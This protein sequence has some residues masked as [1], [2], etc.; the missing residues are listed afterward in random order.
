MQKFDEMYAMLPYEGSDV[1]AHY[2]VY[3]QWL[4]HQRTPPCKPAWRRP[5]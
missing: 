5:R 4:A 3:A 2:K 1:R